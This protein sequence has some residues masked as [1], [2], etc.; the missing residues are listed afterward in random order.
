MHDTTV[1]VGGL[2]MG[3]SPRWH[4]G[5]LW[6]S[7]WAASELL[8]V[9]PDGSKTVVATIDSFPFCIDFLPGETCS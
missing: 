2:A 1:L 6:L 5:R 7:D 8:V 4:D 3:E 9:D